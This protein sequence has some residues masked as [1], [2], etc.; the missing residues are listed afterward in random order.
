MTEAAMEPQP[1]DPTF[2]LQDAAMRYGLVMFRK[3]LMEMVYNDH[4]HK[5]SKAGEW[6][7]QNLANYMK[8]GTLPKKRS[9]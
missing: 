6:W 2:L 8:D 7:C 1:I 9:A 3:L 5:T 4:P